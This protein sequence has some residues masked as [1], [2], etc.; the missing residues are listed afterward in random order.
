MESDLQTT[1][2]SALAPPPLLPRLRLPLPPLRSSLR[3]FPALPPRAAVA[4]ATPRAAD[5]ATSTVRTVP[6]RVVTTALRASVSVS[7]GRR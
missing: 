6:L 1:V 4:R 7:H 3:S 5:P 2:R